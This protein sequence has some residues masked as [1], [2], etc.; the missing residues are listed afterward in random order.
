MSTE[1]FWPAR[2]SVATMAGGSEHTPEEER[3][4]GQA[5]V[6]QQA[7]QTAAGQ[8]RDHWGNKNSDHTAAAAFI[9]A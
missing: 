9:Q 1:L 5:A 7:G 2:A 3:G 6:G 4:R 8:R